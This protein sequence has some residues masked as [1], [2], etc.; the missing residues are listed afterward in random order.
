[1][2]FK[3]SKQIQSFTMVQLLHYQQYKFDFNEYRKK[4]INWKFK[5]EEYLAARRGFVIDNSEE[6]PYIY[7][8]TDKKLYKI[9]FENGKLNEDFN[10]KGYVSNIFSLTAPFIAGN[11]IYVANV[12]PPSLIIFNKKTGKKFHL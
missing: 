10:K 7:A 1:M 3:I 8:T 4:K 2:N 5:F 9:N 12:T 11:K 6:E